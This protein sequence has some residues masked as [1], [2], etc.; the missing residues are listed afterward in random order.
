MSPK[1]RVRRKRPVPSPEQREE[2]LRWESFENKL[3]QKMKESTLRKGNA[4]RDRGLE[5]IVV[6]G[7][8]PQETPVSSQEIIQDAANATKKKPSEIQST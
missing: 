1:E 5:R 2:Q 6:K 3:S 7:L 8:A 4:D